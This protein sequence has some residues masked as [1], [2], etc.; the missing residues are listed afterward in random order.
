MGPQSCCDLH[1]P[2]GLT[3]IVQQYVLWLEVTV[4]N[5]SLMQ[6]LQA[7]NDLCCVVDGPWLREARVLLI[8][9]VDVVP[10]DRTPWEARTRA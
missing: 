1:A 4:D 9:I 8:H 6:V 3:V 7:T 10:E 2:H 5:A